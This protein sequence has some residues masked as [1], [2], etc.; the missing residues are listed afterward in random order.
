MKVHDETHATIKRVE[1]PDRQLMGWVV[2][3]SHEGVF[4]Y[5]PDIREQKEHG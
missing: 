4:R 5:I 3:I 2:P 1:L